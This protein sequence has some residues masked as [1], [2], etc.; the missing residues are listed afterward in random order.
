MYPKKVRKKGQSTELFVA[1]VQVEVC[2]NTRP[3]IDVLV[4]PPTI[5]VLLEATK[6]SE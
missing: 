6:N 3:S 4:L 5:H 2:A 1:D